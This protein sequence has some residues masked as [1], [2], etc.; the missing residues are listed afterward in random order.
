MIEI[1]VKKIKTAI[2]TL[3]QKSAV[4]LDKR[5]YELMKE[6][7]KK[8]QNQSSKEVLEQILQNIFLAD[9][10]QRPLCQDTGQVIVFLE[11]GQDVHLTEGSLNLAI[12]EAVGECYCENYLRKSVN[13]PLAREN[14]TDN[15]PAIIHTEIVDGEAVKISICLKGGGSENMSRSAMLYP[16]KG[17][18]GVLDFVLETVKMASLKSCPPFV[19]GVGI[20]GNLEVSGEIAKK[21]LVLNSPATELER[22]FLEAVNALNIGASGKGGTTTALDLR[23]IEKPCHIASLP[24]SVALNCHAARHSSAII[25]NGE[26]IYDFEDYTPQKIESSQNAKEIFA[27]DIE[28]FKNI[29]SGEKI[30]LTGKIYTARDEA[31]KRLVA[32]ANKPF[33]IKNSII[34]YAGPCPAKPGEVIGPIGPTTST[35]MDSYTEQLLEE[36]LLATIGKGERSP[37]VL[38]AH[39]KHGAVY[40]TAIGGVATLLGQCVKSSKLIAY[41]DLGP[42]AIYELYVEKMPLFVFE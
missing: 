22:E 3:C 16:A 18:K 2:K 26:I 38:E 1:S 17:K 41:E 34:F 15:S 7:C 25:K 23:I 10:A 24:V 29:K 31:H 13:S 8:E 14:T 35:R 21:A 37:E 27:T 33:E 32:D 40:L 6:A 19:I 11:I 42:E 36:G 9:K 39:K 30:L 4:S 28:A 5:T 20:G 12:N